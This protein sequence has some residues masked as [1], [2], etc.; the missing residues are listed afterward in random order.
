M[1][2]RLAGQKLL[3]MYKSNVSLSR[4]CH[5]LGVR[6]REDGYRT[7]D[8]TKECLEEII[9]ALIHQIISMDGDI[10]LLL[11]RLWLEMRRVRFPITTKDEWEV[12]KRM[13]VND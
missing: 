1:Q 10:K 5:T 3:L 2:Q 12:F 8:P 11:E 4:M 6:Y 7:G 9:E 13:D